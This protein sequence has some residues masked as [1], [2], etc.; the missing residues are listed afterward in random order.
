MANFIIGWRGY[1]DEKEK[2][3]YRPVKIE[4]N[5][6]EYLERKRKDLE[7]I[8]EILSSWNADPLSAQS[9]RIISCF[10]CKEKVESR[11]RMILVQEKLQTKRLVKSLFKEHF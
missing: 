8:N 10:V 4:F 1:K 6:L 9:S 2:N 7:E 3:L 5:S 11:K